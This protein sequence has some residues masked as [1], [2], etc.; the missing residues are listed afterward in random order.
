VIDI[1]ATL[2]TAHSEKDGAGGTYTLFKH[3]SPVPESPYDVFPYVVAAWLAIGLG[4][5]LA[6]PGFSVRVSERLGLAP[7]Q[8]SPRARAASTASERVEAESL[9]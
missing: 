8:S 1:D 3:L 6:V 2:I 7:A 5:T 9:R 4:I